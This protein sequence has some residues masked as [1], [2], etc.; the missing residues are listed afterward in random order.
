MGA[1]FVITIF[2]SPVVADPDGR[3][4]ESRHVST[5]LN[6]LLHTGEFQTDFIFIG[7]SN[8]SLHFTALIQTGDAVPNV[9]V[10]IQDLPFKADVAL[11][12]AGVK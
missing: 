11:D 12:E 6:L 9:P 8:A 10:P 2:V 1:I 7:E 4:P 3:I 5:V